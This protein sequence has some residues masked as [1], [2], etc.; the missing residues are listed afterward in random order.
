MSENDPAVQNAVRESAPLDALAPTLLQQN[1][2]AVA[3][4]YVSTSDV[5][6][7]YPMGT[8]EGNA[9]PDTKLTQ[10]PW[11]EPTSPA[12]NPARR[13]TWSPLYLDGAGNGL[14]MT[15]CT[16]VYM[17][18][19]F[20]GVVCLDVTLRRMLDH[21]KELKLTPNSYAF[22]TDA[23]GRLIAGSPVAI[24]ELTGHE[25]VPVPEDRSQPIGL[26]LI[27]TTI[28]EM[29]HAGGNDVQTI[30]IGDKPVFLA[31]SKLGDLNWRLTIVAPIEEVTAQSGTVVAAIQAST[32]SM[33][34]STILAMIGFLILALGGAAL[35]SVRL[36]RPIATLVA[37]T[38]AV[39]RG[40]L[41]TTLPIETN[42]ELGTLA[43]SFNQMIEQLRDQRATTEQAR[44]IAEQANRAK[45]EFLA[46]MSH[47]LRTPLTAIIGYSDLLL[48]QL[49][50][51]GD[52]N[53]TDVD[54][55]R[56]SGKHLLA[57]ISDILDLSKIEASKMDLD[58]GVFK[59]APLIEEAVMTIQPLVEQN[60]NT[61]ILRCDENAGAMYSDMTKVRQVLLNLLSN[62]AKFTERG[63]ITVKVGREIVDQQ[64]W[65]CFQVADT[66][67]GMTSDQVH[68]LFQAFT[69]AD[70]ST[71][72]K[73]GGTGL[74]LALSHR[75][76]HLMGGEIT[77]ASELGIG[78]T[79]TIRLPA[80]IGG[81]EA[82]IEMRTAIA[83]DEFPWAPLSADAM[84]WVGSLVLV[85]AEDPSVG[86]VLTRYLSEEGLLVESAIGAEE[87]KRRARAIRPDM[88]FLDTPISGLDSWNASAGF[89]S[90]PYLTDIPVI[91]LMAG[92]ER[93]RARALND[94]DYLLKPIERRC[95][96][97]LLRKYRPTAYDLAI[98]ADGQPIEEE[99]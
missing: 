11:F 8:L 91:M 31:T 36:T 81:E 5:S 76:C 70:A 43:A 99:S 88:I 65:V 42:D 49:Q 14:M 41:T 2:Q 52:I 95:L 84:D 29:I 38:Q 22:L 71:T 56:R 24:R 20:K 57:I 73:Y 45:S 55:I 86:D 50:E 46:N 35:F 12:A 53:V 87:G 44:V 74:G 7:Y 48:Y 10:E 25:T 33:I 59:V 18:D 61:V 63:T 17:R 54:A 96:M 37:G 64:A 85:I 58:L 62:A 67:I 82:E 78:S 79:F 77:A 13:T 39:A 98:A 9:P 28:R 80:V 15:T 40:D 94:A 66:G 21:L 93:A 75:L 23:D 27:D 32:A 30:E 4:Y 47:E 19:S 34:Q 3:V 90:D 6:R 16:P 72:R 26:T 51:H 69:Q 97:E 83:E 68:R 60:N 92:E 1:T 89:T